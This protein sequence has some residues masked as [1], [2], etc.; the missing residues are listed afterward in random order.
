MIVRIIQLL[1]RFIFIVLLQVVVLNHIQFN[2]YV[3]PYIYLLFILMLPVETPNWLLLVIAL[4]TGLTIDMF[5]NSGG[6]HA[7]ATVLMGFARPGILR[8]IA[9]RDG[10]ESETRLSPQ[11]MGFNWF[12]TYVSMMVLIHHFAYF[13]LE[14]FT[15]SEF[16]MTFLKVLINS[17]ITIAL[18]ILGQYLF[19]KQ[20]KRNER[21]IG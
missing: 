16:F 19:G 9:P 21:I 20:M 18:I 3:N 13:Y 2:G 4:L 6:M 15:F 10:Y 1:I 17:A 12:V 8:L 11:V 7:A 5:G 14:V